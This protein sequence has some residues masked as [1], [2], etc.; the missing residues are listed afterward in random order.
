MVKRF[1]VLAVLALT[2]TAAVPPVRTMYRDALAREQA[3]RGALAAPDALATIL[4]DVRSVVAAYESIVRHYPGSG[5]SDNALWNAARLE[6]DAY[7]AFTQPQ[8]KDAAV[9]LLNKLTA[10]Y[11]TS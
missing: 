9:R 4:V 3:V 8:D 6:I 2:S 11:P 5:Y 7:A 1:L 10:T